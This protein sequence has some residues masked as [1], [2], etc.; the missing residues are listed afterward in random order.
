MAQHYAPWRSRTLHDLLDEAAQRF[1][2]RPYVITDGASWTYSDMAAWSMR[3]AAGLQARGIGPA[4][5]VASIMANHPEFVALKFAISRI[6]A[7]AVP[8]NIFNRERELEYL[9]RQSQASM[10]VTMARFRE[11]DY[12]DMLDRL[13]PGWEDHGGGENLPDLATLIV[14]DGAERSSGKAAFPFAALEI[15]ADNFRR[16]EVEPT[17]LCDILYTSGT[18]GDPKGV[19]ITHDMLT[20]TAFGSAY[21]RAFEDGHRILFAL[22]MYH[23]FG[24]VE[25]MLSVPFVGGSF[26]PHLKFDAE[27]MLEA[28]E[29]HRATDALLIP[30][31]TLD[32]LQLARERGFDLSSFHFVLASGGRA[33][34]R[35]WQEIRDVFGVR[36]ITTGYGMTETTASTTVTRPDDPMERLLNTNG[37]LRNV[38]PAGDPAIE[39]RLVDYKVVDPETGADLPVGEIGELV[40]RGIGVTRGYYRKPEAT[41]AAFTADGWLR[42][43][44]LGR[45]D[46][47]RYITLLGRTK[48]S[49]RCGGEQVLPSEVETVL[50]SHP[51][52]LQAHIVPVPDERMGE[53]GVAFV[54]A[55]PGETIDPGALDHFVRERVARF[56][57]PRHYIPLDAEEIP[58]T[59][60]G[61]P[62]KFLLAEMAMQRLQGAQ[63]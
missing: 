17:Q 45:I 47:D 3:I 37:R 35:I 36:E 20:R 25:G 4:D 23:V 54:V 60:S 42:T 49:Y 2:E 48:E 53:V 28:I 9:L 34:E 63:A 19:E 22:P 32:M 43:G 18:T 14:F 61:R 16:E 26:I 8:L 33:P 50:V 11:L 55:R 59:A 5:K 41:A 40:A 12:L 39:N 21:G 27:T 6:G 1:P 30:T 57:V 10:L 51:T 29:R 52:V 24:Y 56:K 38:G 31:M 62:R 13:A 44:D 46:A 15:D 58:V 7:I